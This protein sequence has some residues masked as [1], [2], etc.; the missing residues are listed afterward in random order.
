MVTV[1][2]RLLES[3]LDS[4]TER[5]Y[6]PA[7]IQ[8]LV[9]EGWTVLHNTR[10][11]PIEFGKDV[12][13]RDPGGVLHCFQLKGNPGSRVTKSE[14]ASL[15]TQFNELLMTAPGPEFRKN[16]D[17]KH[18]AVFVTNG[19]IDEEARL[20][21]ERAAE[22]CK[23]PGAMASAYQLWSRGDLLQKLGPSMRIWPVTLDGIRLVLNL[24]A[25]DGREPPDPQDISRIM[26]LL[27]PPPDASSPAKDSA[28]SSMLVVAEIIK[29]RWYERDNHQA[30]HC[31]TV[32]AAIAAM[33][34][35]DNDK[36]LAMLENYASLALEHCTDLL[37]EAKAKNFSPNRVWSER[38]VLGEYDVMWERRRLVA[39]CAAIALIGRAEMSA[40]L[41][42]YAA[43]LVA[44]VTNH[45]MLWRQAQIPS[46][47]AAFWARGR[48]EA[49]IA[50]EFDLA[51]TLRRFQEL[52]GGQDD[53]AGLPQPYYGWPD[54][55]AYFRNLP[56]MTDSG[57]FEDSAHGHLFFGRAMMFM[58]AKR[59]MKRTCGEL[60][61]G[62][63]RPI[64][65]EP[66]LPA[67]S[68]F[69]AVHTDDGAMH[70]I[71]L[72]TGLWA[73]LVNEGINAASAAAFLDRFAS[74]AWLVAAY[75]SLVPYRGWTPVLM[76]LD[77]RLD[78]SWYNEGERP[79]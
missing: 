51:A 23:Q 14:A 9:S 69:S 8:M 71:Q 74:L 72:R 3:W 24:L 32:L 34:L 59:N 61:P 45:V 67:D 60:W 31:V 36:R 29:A 1:A 12:I 25:G 28:L 77:A 79:R 70:Q 5:R 55:W 73:D 7:F 26:A 15:L 6:Q 18:V 62:F 30:L 76:W 38:D 57:I 68:F 78:R 42:G 2:E 20:L 27:L 52:N 46:L 49:G 44:I 64:H 10:H 35:A 21:F 11:A 75:V 19:E 33:Q 17:E 39:D 54:A 40:E 66:Q 63:T 47:I 50:R 37:A 43:E 4:Q 48:V 53:T 13:A 22:I 56:H 16:A 58:L 41:R 65:E